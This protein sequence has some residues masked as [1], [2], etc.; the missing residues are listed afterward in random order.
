MKRLCYLTGAL[1]SGFLAA[2]A[3]QTPTT[4][5]LP[6][7]STNVGGA[8]IPTMSQRLSGSGNWGVAGKGRVGGSTWAI[9]TYCDTTFFPYGDGYDCY[10]TP[11]YLN[12]R[13]MNASY[14]RTETCQHEYGNPTCSGILGAKPSLGKLIE[15]N[16]V[17]CGGT[18]TIGC[19]VNADQVTYFLDQITVTSSTLPSGAP[20]K[21]KEVVTLTGGSSSETGYGGINYAQYSVF[22]GLFL[23][24]K[25][26]MLYGGFTISPGKA[27]LKVKSN[28][29]TTFAWAPY[30]EINFG[31]TGAP[32]LA[33]MQL[34]AVY[35]LIPVTPNVTLVSASGTRY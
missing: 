3:S 22:S 25:S 16:S 19:G 29:G 21:I 33:T 27:S 18:G 9:F 30:A 15:S 6:W 5:G 31:I 4:A 34:K 7:S 2:C 8:Q 14:S 20:V 23:Y 10:D 13:S 28:V 24:D 26:P 32:N 11:P 35:H 1:F 17:S 12:Q